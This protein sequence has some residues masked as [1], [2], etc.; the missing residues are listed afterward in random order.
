MN[1]IKN[2]SFFAGF[3][4]FNLAGT[5]QVND[6]WVTGDGEKVF[7]KD[8]DHTD[9]NGNSIWDG[10]TIRL[11]GLYNEVRAFQVIVET[12]ESGAEAVEIAVT[13]P[14]NRKSGKAIGGN[15]LKYGPQGTI[16]VF[17]EH[18]L[19]VTDTTPPAWYYGGPEAAPEKMKGCIPDTLIPSSDALRCRG[20]FSVQVDG[21]VNQGF[22]IDLHLPRDQENF[23][24]GK[25]SGS[26]Q[27]LDEGNLVADLPLEVDL[28]PHYLPDENVTHVWMVH[29]GIDH[30]YPDYDREQ[31]DEMI[32][33]EGHRH[34]VEITGGMPVNTSA[35]DQEEMAEFKPY[36]DGTAYTPVNGYHGPGKSLL[37]FTT[38]HF[39]ENLFG[40]VD[41]FAAKRHHPAALQYPMCR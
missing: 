17:T 37:V 35:F 40:A 26:V 7:K 38:T 11:T 14:I 1:R 33:F 13:A 39:Q 5:A 3:M 41:I 30:Y 27:V 16:E 34:R 28:L 10:S 12:G 20:G 18:Y 23:P 6:V 31:A 25:Y 8:L 32:K 21:S 2:V 36:L 15:T 24:S 9:K 29:E 4:L 19:H 22:W